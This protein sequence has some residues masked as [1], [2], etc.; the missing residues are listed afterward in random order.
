MTTLPI[1]SG[2]SWMFVA[3][4]EVTN[5]LWTGRGT[6]RR[7]GPGFLGG[8]SWTLSLSRTS[9]EPILKSLV[10]R[11]EAPVE[12]GVLLWAVCFYLIF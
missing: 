9:I 5:I 4:A 6:A 10:G 1:P 7:R 11:L 2:G 3:V 8:S 12:E